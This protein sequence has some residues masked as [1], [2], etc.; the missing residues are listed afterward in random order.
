MTVFLQKDIGLILENIYPDGNFCDSFEGRVVNPGHGNES[1]WFLM[2]LAERYNNPELIKQCEEILIRTTEF[3]WDKEHGGIFYFLD[4]K[5]HPVQQ[6]EWDQK[7][8]WVH[9]ESMISFAKAYKITG[10]PVAKEWFL[11]L[12][13][14]TWNHFRD[15]EYGEWYG[16]LTRQG[17]PLLTLKGGKWKGCFHVP[18]GLYQ[19]WKTLE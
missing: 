6:L 1:M 5:G 18:R 3:G 4:I 14:Y 16:Y 2:D 19:L 11:R 8:W 17:Q 12:H 9:I 10:N 15:S 13:D 7:L